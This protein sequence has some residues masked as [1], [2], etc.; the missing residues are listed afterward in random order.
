MRFF[1]QKGNIE[2]T[3]IPKIN[4]GT[5]R[6][7]IDVSQP[8]SSDLGQGIAYELLFIMAIAAGLF[9]LRALA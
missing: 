6:K 3:L 5:F 7:R 1:K 2:A 9:G 8:T 4:G